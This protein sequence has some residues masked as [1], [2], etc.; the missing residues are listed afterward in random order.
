M[1]NQNEWLRT[2][3][4]LLEQVKAQVELR[5][6]PLPPVLRKYAA[7]VERE[8]RGRWRPGVEDDLRAALGRGKIVLAAD[9]HAYAQ[10]QRAHVRILRDHVQH[11]RVVLALECLAQ[12][13][14]EVIR[15]FVRGRMSEARFLETVRWDKAWGFPWENYRP[16]FELARDRGFEVRGLNPGRL[17]DLEKR[18]RW[19]AER[20][21][22]LRRQ[23][24]EALVFAVI[25]EWHLADAHLPKRLR[26]GL[27]HA[28]DLV[29]IFQ[30]VENLY[31]KLAREDAETAVDLLVKNRNRFCLMVSPPWMKWQSYLMYLEQAYDRDL[32]EDLAIDYSDHVVSLVELLENDL[33]IE[34]RKA[35][36]QV[37]CPNSRTPLARL[38]MSLP[39]G[40]AK[41]LVYHLEH[42]LSFFLVERD[43]LYL[44]RPTIN[45]ASSLAG[46]FVHAHLSKRQRTLWNVPHDF[47]ALIW[48][49]AI[50][51]FFSKWINP[52]RKAETLESIR[53]QLEARRPKDRGRT[54]LLLALD[55]RL[56]EVVWVQTGRL[57][58]RRF[59]P[60]QKDAYLESARIIGSMLGERLFQKVRSK[61]IRWTR[62][63]SY[64]RIKVEDA[65]FPEFYWELV[66][67]LEL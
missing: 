59:K 28:D 60:R 16:L 20:L 31:F 10:S 24:P 7:G 22:R 38:K 8:F 25:G 35:R 55:H 30:D 18:D 45:H 64:L 9:F 50:G 46:Q 56:S 17:G 57:R 27:E 6:G 39:R 14:D 54:A 58:R 5:L 40:Q 12:K 23:D 52:K 21:L 47:L 44:S 26:G 15:E 13:H 61:T 43:W 29:V 4:K 11:E 37:Y 66:R 1:I 2:R 42:D 53:L 48:I 41:A 33:K 32:Q 62:L 49:E 36:V 34:T 65:D 19:T 67:E 3:R 63:M 51:F